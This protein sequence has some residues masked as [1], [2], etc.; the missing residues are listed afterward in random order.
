MRS[1]AATVDDFLKEQSETIRKDLERLRRLV[2]SEAPEAR[3]GMRYGGPVH[4]LKAGP[5]LCGFTAQ[6]HNLAFYVGRVPDEIRDQ[7]RAE[8][9]NLGKG[10]VRFKKLD[11]EK[12]AALRTLLR[13]V[14]TEGITC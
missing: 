8:G 11:S 2:R 12:M 5:I 1:G 9:F 13:H 7:M 6:K 14:I 3:E 4:T 10:A